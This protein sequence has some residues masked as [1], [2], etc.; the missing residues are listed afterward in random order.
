MLE[1]NG[2]SFGC[3]RTVQHYLAN[4]LD[5]A[6]SNALDIARI[7][8]LCE[9]AQD[10]DDAFGKLSSKDKEAG[11]WFADEEGKRTLPFWLRSIEKLVGSDGFAIGG[12]LS[13]ADIV[14]YSKFADCCTTRGLFGPPNSE[15]FGSKTKT[16]DA[17]AKYAPKLGSIL[18]QL[19]RKPEMQAYLEA[20]AA[21]PTAAF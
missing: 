6:G 7:D 17:L 2:E 9:L 13:A 8:N 5:L 15:P 11:A 21:A 12:A 1:V 19:H 4:L 16:D 10:A 20:R 14:L 18:S 3:R